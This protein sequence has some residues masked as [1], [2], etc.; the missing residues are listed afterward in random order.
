MFKRLLIVSNTPSANTRELAD[1][2]RVGANNSVLETIQ[3]QHL[4]PLL[5]TAD[6][7]LN[8]SAIIIGTTEN[9]GYMS[10]ALKDFFERI[11]YPCLEHTQGLPWT[12]YVRAG[13]DGQGALASVQRIVSGLRWREV[14]V[15]LVMA[16]T[17]QPQFKN[18]CKELGLLMAAGLDAGIF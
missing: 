10:G 17:W 1:A 5:A 6:D 12:L 11:Y 15:P 4:E 16:G 2:V 7:V 14:N 13:N 8:A 18:D 3:V 9:F